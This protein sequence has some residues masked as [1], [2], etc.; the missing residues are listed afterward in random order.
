MIGPAGKVTMSYL[1]FAKHSTDAEVRTHVRT[2]TV[3]KTVPRVQKSRSQLDL[4]TTGRGIGRVLTFI[5][6]AG[7]ENAQIWGSRW[8]QK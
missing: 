6:F 1:F 5:W 7:I 3:S 4:K 8:I 2:L